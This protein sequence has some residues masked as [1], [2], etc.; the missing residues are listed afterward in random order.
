MIM[1]WIRLCIIQATPSTKFCNSDVD[2]YR[3]F[4]E[5]KKQ[6]VR[7]IG[8]RKM[9]FAIKSLPSCPKVEYY[10][11]SSDNGSRDLSRTIVLLSANPGHVLDYEA[12]I[13]G[14]EAKNLCVIGLNWPGYGESSIEN[15]PDISGGADYFFRVLVEF[16]QEMGIKQAIF[17][18]NSVGGYAALRLGIE[19]PDRVYKIVLVSSGGFSP[20][21]ALT[22]LFCKFMSSSIAPSPKTFAEFYLSHKDQPVPVEILK[23]A[24][25]QNDKLSLKI[26]HAVWASFG[27]TEY[28]FTSEDVLNVEVPVLCIFNKRDPVIRPSHDGKNAKALFANKPNVKFVEMDSGHCPFA[29]IPDEFMKVMDEEHII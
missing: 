6:E 29:E 11:T 3:I 2:H 26:N 15:V 12:I 20:K 10:Q 16:V 18:G 22:R 23:R 19:H 24:E 21:G 5:L 1:I 28:L 25:K 27:R 4:V 13:P 17:I 14:L 8:I 9:P 7:I